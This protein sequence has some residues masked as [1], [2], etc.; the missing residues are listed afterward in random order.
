MATDPRVKVTIKRGDQTGHSSGPHQHFE[1]HRVRPNSY[2]MVREFQEKFGHRMDKRPGTLD[3]D[4]DFQKMRLN[5][6]K[7][8]FAELLDACGYLDAAALIENLDLQKSTEGDVIGIADALGDLEYVVNGM[9]LSAGIPLPEVVAE[10]HRSNMTKLGRDGKP[11]IREDG[12]F[13]KG[14]DYEE[15]DL[16]A[17][18][19]PENVV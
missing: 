8:E 2:E 1:I 4:E 19:W 15:P 6:I 14:E 5:L 17:V 7:E 13:L 11:I 18:L 12:K 10:I 3:D 9:A 16:Q